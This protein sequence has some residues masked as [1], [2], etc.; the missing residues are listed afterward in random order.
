MRS[1]KLH[2]ATKKDERPKCGFGRFRSSSVAVI[3]L[4]LSALP[5]VACSRKPTA[6]A[7]TSPATTSAGPPALATMGGSATSMTAVR[8]LERRVKEDPD[9]LVALNKLANYYLQLYRETN[10]VAYLQLA[11]HSARSSLNVV[12]VDQNLGGLLAMAQAEYAT[13]DFAGARDHAKQ[14]TEYQPQKSYG[15]QVLGDALLELGEYEQ[16]THAY[17]RMR[18]LDSGSVT[19][20]TRLAHLAM[21]RGDTALA[22]RRYAQAVTAAQGAPIPAAETIAWCYWQSGETDF[23]S[24]DYRSAERH[25]GEALKVY[26]DYVRALASLGRVRA[27]LGDR[28]GAITQY[29]HAVSIMPDPQF[30]AAMGDLYKLADRADDAARLYA[31][32]EKI[33]HLNQLNGTLYSRQMALFYADHEMKLDEAYASAARDYSLR[34]DVYGADT[35]AW[36][37]LKVGKIAEAHD[38]IKEALRLGTEDARIFYHAGMIERAAG[39]TAAA[40]DYLRRSLKLNPHFDP[41]QSLIAKKALDQ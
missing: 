16:A 9:D 26:P 10:D 18:E 31:L 38:A 3:A 19:S 40:H 14:L 1:A 36:T 17:Q 5:G 33:G 34:R 41:L 21:L 15:Y 7:G 23:Q 12:G 2:R 11:L 29:E 4:T 6:I 22:K 24:G 32:V 8:F 28:E 13:H 27:A 37:A 20:E 25:Y 30:V 35:L 39:D